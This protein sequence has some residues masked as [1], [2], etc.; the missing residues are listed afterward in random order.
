MREVV[1]GREAD[2]LPLRLLLTDS[3]ASEALVDVGEAP[4]AGALRVTLRLMPGDAARLVD[5][6]T[7][8]PNDWEAERLT[9]L[10]KEGEE[11]LP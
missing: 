9:D 11:L 4:P 3:E 2:L 5:G 1:G 8:M 7:L 6:V 10:L